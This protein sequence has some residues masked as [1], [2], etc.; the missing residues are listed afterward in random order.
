M[1]AGCSGE[2]MSDAREGLCS[3]PTNQEYTLPRSGLI[4]SRHLLV[5]ILVFASANH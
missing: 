1:A 3:L 5:W 4:K 2:G